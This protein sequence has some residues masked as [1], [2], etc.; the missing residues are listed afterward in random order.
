MNSSTAHANRLSILHLLCLTAG[1]GIAI[2]ITRGIDRLRFSA[3]AIYYNLDGIQ[4]IDAF[5]AL[6]AAVYGVC[7]TTFIFA[8]RS[9]DLWGSP[10]KTLALLF[11]TMCVLNWTLDLFAAVLMNYRMQIGPP[12]GMPDTRGYITG[13][14][15]RDFA[16]SL[17]YVF[18]LPV[19]ALVVYKTRLQ[20]AS[21]RMVWIGFFVFA[22][23]IV[24]TMHFDVDQH[25]P[26][27]IRPWYFEIAIGIPIVLLALATGLSLLRRERLDWWTTIT[28]P[29]I[30][31]VWG[32][33]VFVKATAA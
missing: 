10:G 26:I 33:G 24:G 15:Y 6:V 19:L 9:G 12:V 18:G 27:A 22:L 1:V 3:D 13:I 21:W 29:L 5:A 32:I 20:G 7:L 14:W 2:T 16:P 11:A 31:V 8:Y 28:A 25:L 17:G 30:I 23:L 4:G